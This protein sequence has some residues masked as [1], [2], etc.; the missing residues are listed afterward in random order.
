MAK[1]KRHIH[2]YHKVLMSYT[3]VWACALPDCNHYM[4]THMEQMVLGK[5]SICWNCDS[6]FILNESNMKNDKP[7][8]MN[9]AGEDDDSKAI[10]EVLSRHSK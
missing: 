2:K 4:P 3:K 7:T 9:C 6:M 10:A 1:A 8:C 5:A